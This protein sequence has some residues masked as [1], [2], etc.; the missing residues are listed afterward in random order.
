MTLTDARLVPEPGSNLPTC[1]GS[2]T[3]HGN[4][5]IVL[6]LGKAQCFCAVRWLT[7]VLSLYI[8]GIQSNR[9]EG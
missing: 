9:G 2:P 5:D 7:W 4:R 3:S 6:Y 8:Q 1:P